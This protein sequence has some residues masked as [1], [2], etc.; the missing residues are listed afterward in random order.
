MIDVRFMLHSDVGDI[1]TESPSNCIFPFFLPL[2]QLNVDFSD[3]TVFVLSLKRS[4]KYFSMLDSTHYIRTALAL[5]SL[6][7]LQAS[8]NCVK[9]YESFYSLA[10]M[11]SNQFSKN[12]FKHKFSYFVNIS[13][14]IQNSYLTLY[15]QLNIAG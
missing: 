3:S 5:T 14:Y 13:I 12:V 15:C 11:Y 4:T 1:N 9:A 10:K 6:K 8:L 2:F 7:W